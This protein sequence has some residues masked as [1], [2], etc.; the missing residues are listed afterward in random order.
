MLD[1]LKYTFFQNALTACILT[2]IVCGLIGTYIVNRRMVFV[3]GGMAHTCLGGVGICALLGWPPMIGAGVFALASGWGIEFLGNK[4]EVRVDSAIAM[5]WALGMSVGITCSFLAPEFLPSLSSYLFGNI[6]LIEATDLWLLAVLACAV[7]LLYIICMPQISSISFDPEYAKAQG[8]PVKLINTLLMGFVAL[9]IV[10]AL[11]VAGVVL[12]ISL[13]S[14]PQMTANL[15]CSRFGSMALWSSVI[16][17]AGCLSGL[18]ASVWLNV[19]CGTMIVAAVI[20]IYIT[21]RAI[22]HFVLS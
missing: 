21:A 16:A 13:L 18:A 5:F 11:K 4:H 17:I 7:T 19:P 1:L 2:G 6:L 15:F 9:S 14:V 20:A 8:Q 12:V 10:S 3:A 22:K